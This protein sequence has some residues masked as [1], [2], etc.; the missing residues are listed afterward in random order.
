MSRSTNLRFS[1]PL[2]MFFLVI[3]TLSQ[4]ACSDAQ[5]SAAEKLLGGV[6]NRID[7]VL[8]EPAE[9]VFAG[10]IVNGENNWQNG[11]VV[12]LFKGEEEIAR[13]VS[14]LR[15][16][17]LVA[18]GPMDGVFE[19]RVANDYKLTP[20]HVFTYTNNMKLEMETV[21]GLVGTQYV[22]GWLQELQPGAV[23]IIQVAE[24]QLRFTVVVLDML[25]SD[26]PESH[27]P[28]RLAFNVK[29]NLLVTNVK[30][31]EELAAEAETAVA[32]ITVTN[33]T[34]VQFSLTT[35]H[36]TTSVWNT[37]MIGYS[38][39]LWD[40]WQNLV[41]GRNPNMSWE[42][43]RNA[44]S[45]YNPQLETDGYVFHAEKSYWLPLN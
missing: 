40:V 23:Q 20:S 36:S 8:E 27:G 35:D 14:G 6:S 13:S 34:N 11:Y 38:G 39:S 28:G 2:V 25:Q 24:K 37:R 4:I 16:N 41:A 15:E 31:A 32:N 1:L 9:L 26:L 18:K 42:T 5:Q 12:V 7:A 22:G 17:P 45:V 43:F 30:T 3:F 10:Q 33:Q 19:L 44:V 29:D 21:S